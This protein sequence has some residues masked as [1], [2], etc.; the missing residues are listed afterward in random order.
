[1]RVAH[2]LLALCLLEDRDQWLQALRAKPNKRS[3]LSLNWLHALCVGE[4]LISK[5]NRYDE[6][7]KAIESALSIDAEDA[8]YYGLQASIYA[9]QEQ[10]ASAL[11]AAE[12]GLSYDAEH[13]TC[14]SI[15]SLSLE[16]LGRVEDALSQANNR[17]RA[18]PIQPM[19]TS[20]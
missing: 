15:R 11:Q 17:Y 6:A 10:W 2:A 4:R 19:R 8:D 14:E 18:V 7:L 1:M 16:R 12:Q 5:R 3:V 20:R 13:S 9:R